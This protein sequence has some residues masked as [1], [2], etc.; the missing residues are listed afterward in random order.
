MYLNSPLDFKHEDGN[1][2]RDHELVSSIL[3]FQ[4]D[5]NM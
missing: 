3:A 5:L 2:I 4:V 1:T